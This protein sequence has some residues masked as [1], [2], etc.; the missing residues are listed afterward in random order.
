[1]ALNDHSPQTYHS[2]DVTEI[3]VYVLNRKEVL[4]L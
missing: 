4:Y 1:M 3:K 2:V